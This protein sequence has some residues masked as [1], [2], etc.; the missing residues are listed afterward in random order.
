MVAA[1]LRN[2]LWAYPVA[3]VVFGGFIVY[4]IYRF[5][6]TGEFGL[7]TLSLFDL[8]VIWLVWP[9]YKTVKL[10]LTD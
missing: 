5:T 9:E 4:Q 8:M 1:L 3:I 10:R 6:L 7:I 2:K